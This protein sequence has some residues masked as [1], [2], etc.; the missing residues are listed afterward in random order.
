MLTVNC[1]RFFTVFHR[2]TALTLVQ[3]VDIS[4]KKKTKKIFSVLDVGKNTKK[5][6]SVLDVEEIKEDNYTRVYVASFTS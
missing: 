2:A 3:L 4:E 1:S 6:F 5:I